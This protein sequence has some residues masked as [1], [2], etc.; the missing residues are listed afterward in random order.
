MARFKFGR[1]N[2]KWLDLPRVRVSPCLKARSE[3]AQ[4]PITMIAPSGST[5]AVSAPS[6]R[7]YI[8]LR[9]HDQQHHEYQDESCQTGQLAPF[10][11]RLLHREIPKQVAAIRAWRPLSAT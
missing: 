9:Q 3:R 10:I 2:A 5:S 4:Q 6:R 11:A 7:A 1:L 8:A